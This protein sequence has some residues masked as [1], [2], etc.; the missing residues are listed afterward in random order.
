MLQIGYGVREMRATFRC[1]PSEA[2]SAWFML[3]RRTLED[4]T[5]DIRTETESCFSVP[6]WSFLTARSS[7]LQVVRAFSVSYELEDEARSL[8][9]RAT[10]QQNAYEAALATQPVSEEALLA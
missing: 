10:G 6:W 1:I 2:Q 5:Q 3:L 7:L 8:L 4:H 9:E